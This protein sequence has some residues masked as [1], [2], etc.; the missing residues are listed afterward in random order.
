MLDNPF[1][2]VLVSSRWRE[3]DKIEQRIMFENSFRD[4]R[5]EHIYSLICGGHEKFEVTILYHHLI[6]SDK[7]LDNTI[8]NNFNICDNV[9]MPENWHNNVNSVQIRKS[10]LALCDASNFVDP[11]MRVF[12][13]EFSSSLVHLSLMIGKLL[14]LLSGSCGDSLLMGKFMGLIGSLKCKSLLLGHI[15]DLLNVS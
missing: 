4:N 6:I 10:Y 11:N 1:N 13:S 3:S 5:F 14:S 8:L 15:C 12:V 2:V 9:I 7:C